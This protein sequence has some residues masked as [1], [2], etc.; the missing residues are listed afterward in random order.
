MDSLS[1]WL[2]AHGLGHHRE[3]FEVNGIGTEYQTVSCSRSINSARFAGNRMTSSVMMT[4]HAPTSGPL[5]K[6]KIDWSK[7]SGG[8]LLSRSD[9]D[10]S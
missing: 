1:S 8:K 10:S 6:S 5:K 7:C 2:E 4:V 9:S 3:Q